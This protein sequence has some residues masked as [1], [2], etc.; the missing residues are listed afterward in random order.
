MRSLAGIVF[1]LVL[2]SCTNHSEISNISSK[3]DKIE[4]KLVLTA[5]LK[6]SYIN[7]SNQRDR[8]YYYLVEIKLINNTNKESEFYTL[9]CGSLVNIITDSRQ[10]SFLYHNCSAELG[11]LIKLK[12]KQEFCIDAIL[13]RNKYMANFNYNI[14]FGFILFHPKSRPLGTLIP[15]T[16]QEII[17]ELKILRE[18][19]D[20][21]IWS[22]PVVLTTA[23]FNP[24]EIRNTREIE[25]H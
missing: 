25:I 4:N 15:L 9:T 20:D 21:V 23:N 19:Q 22:E 11:V 2:L 3:T 13:L 24:Y 17:S 12:P 5:N 6:S 14:R 16:N 18:K 7:Y 8:N 10:V 1:L